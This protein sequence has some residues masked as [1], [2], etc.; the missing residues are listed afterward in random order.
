MKDDTFWIVVQKGLPLKTGIRCDSGKEEAKELRKK[1]TA[2]TGNEWQ[3]KK[4]TP[5][6]FATV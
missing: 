4:V 5:K 1:K 6:E 3:A 2:A